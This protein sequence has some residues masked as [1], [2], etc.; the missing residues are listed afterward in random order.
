MEDVAPVKTSCDEAAK[1]ATAA[2]RSPP[3]WTIRWRRYNPDFGVDQLVNSCF[4]LVR[5]VKFVPKIAV[6]VIPLRNVT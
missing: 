5:G 1:E 6:F 2:G 4:L 3:P